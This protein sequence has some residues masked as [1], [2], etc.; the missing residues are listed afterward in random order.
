MNNRVIV[1]L[2]LEPGS[3]KGLDDFC[4]RTGMTKVAALSRL[5]DW[6]CSQPDNVQ[7]I[8]QGLIPTFITADVAEIILKRLIASKEIQ[9]IPKPS[10]GHPIGARP[11]GKKR[12]GAKTQ[13]VS[14]FV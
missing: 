11:A 6:F 13:A 9:E 1:R 2:E 14:R 7:A 5:I 4:D 10:N 12:N 3:K 8:I